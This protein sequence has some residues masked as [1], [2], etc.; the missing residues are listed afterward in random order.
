MS[1]LWHHVIFV[2]RILNMICSTSDQFKK[3]VQYYAIH[4]KRGVKF[5][6]FDLRRVYGK[7]DNENCGWKIHALKTL[8]GNFQVHFYN[9]KH[10]CN[11]RFNV[12]NIKSS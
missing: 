5:T 3:V 11:P 8:E 6:K 9:P 1:S 12:P 10:Q 7:C 4:E 2:G